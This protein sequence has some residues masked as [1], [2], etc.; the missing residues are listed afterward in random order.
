MTHRA[1]TEESASPFAAWN[2]DRIARVIGKALFW[3]ASFAAPIALLCIVAAG[4][5]VYPFGSESFL[6]ED[7]Q[8]QYIDFFTWWRGVLTGSNDIEYSFAQSIGAGTWGLYSYYLASPFN[9]LVVFFGDDDLTLFSFVVTALKLGCIQVAMAVYLRGRFKLRY[10]WAFLIALSFACSTWVFTQLRNPMWLDS[11]ILLPLAALACHRLIR[12]GSWIPLAVVVGIDIMVCWYMAYISVLFI[13][14]YAL[15]ETATAISEGSRPDA[16][17]VGLRLLAFLGALAGGLLLAAWTFLPTILGMVDSVAGDQ[18]KD[19][20]LTDPATLW[21]A[22]LPGMFSPT[23]PQFYSGIAML[24]LAL[25]FVFNRRIH[26]GV[27]VAALALVALFVASSIFPVLEYVWCGFRVPGGFYSRTAFL[28]PFMFAWMGAYGLGAL[29]IRPR[30][31]VR[32]ALLVQAIISV[33]LVAGSFPELAWNAQTAW[34]KLYNNYPQQQHNAYLADASWQLSE[35]KGKDGSVFYRVDKTYTRINSSAL[36]E[37]LAEGYLSLSSYASTSDRKAISFVNGLGYS[38]EGEFSTRVSSANLVADSLLGLKY[39]S[40]YSMPVGYKD[41]GLSPTSSGAR[42]YQ[43][44]YALSLG[45]AASDRV[46]GASLSDADNPFERQNELVADITGSD[47]PLY[48]LIN[49]DPTRE[50]KSVTWKVPVLPG[51]IAYTYLVQEGKEPLYAK[52]SMKIDDAAPIGEGWRFDHNVRALGPATAQP[53]VHTVNISSGESIPDDTR[54]V[55]YALN[56]STFE[57]LIN[58]LKAH[59]F[60]PTTFDDGHVAGT[61]TAASDG[62]LL[63]SIPYDKGWSFTVN[64][65]PANVQPAFD[66]G[67]TA[68]EVK[69]GDNDIEMTYRTP[70]LAAGCAVTGAAV[71]GLVAGTIIVRRHRRAAVTPSR[72]TPSETSSQEQ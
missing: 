33:A 22:F 39:L 58:T 19:E 69:A 35:L 56:V 1:K 61:Y 29:R 48:T 27:K 51:T 10:G 68:I 47:E 37:G 36:N 30:W 4:S 62:H 31:R 18:I 72:E 42:F 11:L 63:L 41:I 43:N 16:R 65:E 32:R 71:V 20:L 25:V 3:A 7:L 24:V 64:G 66:E 21:Q 53:T 50:E 13:V 8:Y 40:A 46:A 54:C 55:F 14:L 23:T 34:G 15:L 38:S 44:P 12:R 52:L 9:L 59:Q 60:E 26:A 49:V 2:S 5:G 28:V 70:G 17:T 67:M 57:K 6:T 45:Y